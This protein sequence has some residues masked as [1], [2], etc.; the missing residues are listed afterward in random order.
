[1]KLILILT[2]LLFSSFLIPAQAETR[3]DVISVGKG[4]AIIIQAEG[5]TV[6]IDTG[7]GYACGKLRRAFEELGITRLDAVFITHV[8]SDHI[9]G[10][11][12]LRQCGIQVDKWY[13][14]PYFFEYKEKKHP[15]NKLGANVIWLEAGD[16]VTIGEA[17]FEVLAPLVKSEEEE[18]DNSLVMM[19]TTPDGSILLTGDM[20]YPEEETLLATDADLKCDILKV[21]N[22]GDGDATSSAFIK[23]S[24]P[25]YAVISTSSYEKPDTPDPGVMA[26]L[27]AAGAEVFVTQDS[28]AV[29]AVMNSGSIAVSHT[30]W[31]DMPEYSGV[32]M[33]VDKENELFI[34]TNGSGGDISLESWY[35][36]SESGN[37]LFIIPGGTLPANGSITIGTK[38]SPEGRYDIYWDEKNVIAN[39]KDDLISLYDENGK[40]IYSAY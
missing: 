15:L 33:T 1:M 17:R 40:L 8:D 38:T 2:L 5:C 22:H 28:D 39:K 7:K 20:E 19:L 37:E 4:D 18:N 16:V 10:L 32:S 36:Y 26:A 29:T 9:E 21:S 23:R 24:Q 14:S 30:F 27:R 31:Q 25:G 3:M 11:Q 12:F 13:A 6:L 34:I 35:L